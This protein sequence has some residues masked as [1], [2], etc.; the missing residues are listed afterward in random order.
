MTDK[1]PRVT[2]NGCLESAEFGKY[3]LIGRI[4]KGGMAEI[5]LAR[6]RAQKRLVAI[7]VVLNHLLKEKQYVDMFVLEGKL[8]VLLNHDCIVKTYEIGI[9]QGRHFICMEH[10]SGV[11][12]SLLLKRVRNN[13]S[14]RFPI[15]HA[16]YIGT[17]ICEGLHYAHEL[18]DSSGASLNVVNRDVSPSNIRLSFEGEVKLLDFGIAK[19]ASGLSSEIGVLKGK[20]SHMSPEQV[21]GLPLD[22]RSDVFS[23][24]IVLHEILTQEKLFRG[25][26]DF[27]LMDLVRKAEV[28]PPSLINPR[29]PPEVD[30]LVLKALQKTPEDRFQSAE[31][32]AIAL[33]EILAHYSFNKTELKEFVRDICREEWNHEQQIIASALNCST[34]ETASEPGSDENYGEFLEI[35]TSTQT[36]SNQGSKSKLAVPVWLWGLLALSLGLLFF[37]LFLL[38]RH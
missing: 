24:G 8:G 7:K 1:S 11:D 37:S 2:S 10:I 18:K 13:P 20:V 16:L 38:I 29:V 26:S 15:P 23:T 12:L 9:I 17:R 32:M 6:P 22:R 3:L 25:S 33:R 34:P 14:L 35:H 31:E 28:H 36:L 30:A 21:R 19:A 5:F 27:Q 4:G